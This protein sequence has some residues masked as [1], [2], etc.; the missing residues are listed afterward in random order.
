PRAPRLTGS[1]R[2]VAGLW[3]YFLV[4]LSCDLRLKL[5]LVGVTGNRFPFE[6]FGSEDRDQAMGEVVNLRNRRKAKARDDRSARAAENC[7]RFGRSLAE[8]RLVKS[9]NVKRARELD[10]RC[11][12]SGDES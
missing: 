5:R 7:A 11:L 1:D 9:A 8:R 6:C 3:Y 12:E 2:A 10:G 4:R